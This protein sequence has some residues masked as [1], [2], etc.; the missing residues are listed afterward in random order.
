MPSAD[1]E[2]QLER[3]GLDSTTCRIAYVAS[4]RATHATKLWAL[5]DRIDWSR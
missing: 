5:F 3:G 2:D 4:V 1:A